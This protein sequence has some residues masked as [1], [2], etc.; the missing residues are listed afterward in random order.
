MTQALEKAFAELT[1][2]PENEQDAIAAWLMEELGSEKRWNDT[3]E[4][5]ADLLSQLADEALADLH[6]GRTEPLDPDR[7]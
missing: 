2:L 3:F 1:K 4:Q 6:E 5:S 7:L